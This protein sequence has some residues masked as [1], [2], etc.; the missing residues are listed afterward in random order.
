MAEGRVPAQ[1]QWAPRLAEF[2]LHVARYAHRSWYPNALSEAVFDEHGCIAPR[3][4]PQLS[5]WL[6]RELGLRRDMDWRMHEPHKRLWLL[7]RSSIQQLAYEVAVAMHRDWL[8]LVIDGARLRALKQKLDRQ[9]WRLMLENVPQGLCQHRSPVVDFETST[10]LE[11]EQALLADGAATLLALLQPAWRAVRGRA[12]LHFD[13]ALARGRIAPCGAAR[14]DE[15]LELIC[16]HV[17]PKRLPQWAWL[18]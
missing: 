8:A 12:Q 13:G 14:C 10:Q 3:V 15:L 6:L 9:L 18:F 7:D 16:A 1:T 5:D 4:E 2:N 11:I 17:I